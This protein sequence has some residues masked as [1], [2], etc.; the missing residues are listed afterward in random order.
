MHT[1]PY[2]RRVYSPDLR[3]VLRW[4]CDIP[5]FRQSRHLALKYYISEAVKL[6]RFETVSIFRARMIP[7]THPT[8]LT[9]T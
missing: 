6:I 4:K 7:R 3:L 9:G 5:V 8:S 2:I 1:T